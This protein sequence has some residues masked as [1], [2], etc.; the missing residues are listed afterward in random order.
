MST[1]KPSSSIG[2]QSLTRAQDT[3][4]GLKKA[5]IYVEG[6]DVRLHPKGVRIVVKKMPSDAK[7]GNTR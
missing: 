3:L 2:E 5:G 7:R 6:M 1:S 4:E